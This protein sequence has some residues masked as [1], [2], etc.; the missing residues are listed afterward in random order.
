MLRTDTINVSLSG[1]PDLRPCVI[2]ISDGGG[3][4][5]PL[6]IVA[7]GKGEIG[8]DPTIL[9]KQGLT[10]ALHDGFIPPF[11]CVIVA[12]QSPSWSVPPEWLP[13]I[14]ANI[15]AKIPQVDDSRLIVTGLSAGGWTAWGSIYNLD[16][17]FMAKVLGV[18]ALS[19]AT[20]DT[21]K[22]NV[23]LRTPGYTGKILSIYGDADLTVNWMGVRDFNAWINSFRPGAVEEV[24]R[25]GVAHTGWV[26]IYNG[27][28]RWNGK[29]FW[30]W[31]AALF[32]A[33]ITS[34]TTVAPAPPSTT[35]TVP[36]PTT[37]TTTMASKTI[38]SVQINYTDGSSIKI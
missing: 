6:I 15:K 21:N 24:V 20:G 12:P 31:A 1:T 32:G 9:Y 37:T 28:F 7:H 22:A 25:A 34:T 26:E 18:A 10:K 17:T 36:P 29:S 8:T 2:Y 5:L 11:P 13:G 35:T 4:N 3:N 30:T 33:V 14:L 23:P 38:A 19:A 16:L 27:S